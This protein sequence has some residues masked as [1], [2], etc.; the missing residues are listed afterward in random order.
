M[1][2]FDKI[3]GQRQVGTWRSLWLSQRWIER[4]GRTVS[5][6][7]LP[8]LACFFVYLLTSNDE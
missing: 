6:A 5:V 7:L 4:F 2:I 8:F 1:E 3:Y